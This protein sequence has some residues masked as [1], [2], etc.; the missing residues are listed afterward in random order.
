MANYITSNQV[1]DI[2]MS[3]L[4]S[5]TV[6]KYPKTKPDSLQPTEYIVVNTLGIDADVMQF[7]HV[8]VN[9]HVKDITPGMPDNAK[10]KAGEALVM[11]ILKKVTSN[12]YM[13]D[14]EGQYDEDEPDQ[15]EHYSNLKFK[16]IQIN[17]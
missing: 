3:L 14:F 1:I 8:N 7:C 15:K 11:S 10:I 17:N 16:F 9:Y 6:P 2:V 12:S 4:T 5:I 13:I